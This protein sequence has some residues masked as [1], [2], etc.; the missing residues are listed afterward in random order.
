VLR[1]QDSTAPAASRSIADLP[2]PPRLPLIGS[3]HLLIRGSRIHQTVERWARRYG[4]ILRAD[5]G[6]RR[7]I[8]IAD[9]DAINEIL[10]NRPDGFRRWTDQQKIL[11]E[12]G[13][14]SVF[15]AEGDDWKRQRRLVV[16]ALNINKLQRYFDVIRTSGLRLH[17]QLAEAAAGRMTLDIVDELTS[18]TVDI[19]SALVFGHDLNTLERRDNELQGHIQRMMTMTSRRLAAPVPYWRWVRL[20]ADRALDRSLATM[21]R[22]VDEFIAQ[23]HA[24]MAERPE[25]HDDPENLLE[26]MLAAQAAEGTFS[27]DDI[28]GNVFGLLAAGEDTTA[29]TLGWT[30]WLLASQPG[31]QERLAHEAREALGSDPVPGDYQTLERLPYTEAV[32]RESMRLRPVAP[33]MTMEP[34]VDATICDTLIP[35]GTRL[36]LLLRAAGLHDG[37]DAGDFRPERWM[38]DDDPP[39][40]SVVFGAGPRFCPGRNLA[41]AEVKSALAMITRDF[42]ITLDPAARPVRE[43]LNFAMVPRGLRVQ[44]T[45][46]TAAA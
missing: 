12:F 8:A 21:R 33:L 45:P 36:L 3:A 34:L 43:S 11:E 18:Y 19:T 16:T 17:R 26:A 24:R 38:T 25:L 27:D 35:A 6:P 46:R 42:A 4:P 28:V 13:P 30:V 40:K 23:A 7:I 10:R 15:P 32:L 14:L 1:E 2:G 39:P 9:A 41:F 5:V 20:P 29:H 44:L 22:T 37:P 31:V